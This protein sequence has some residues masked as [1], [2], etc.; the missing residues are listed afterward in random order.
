MVTGERGQRR[1]ALG[2]EG[3][4]EARRGRE[5]ASVTGELERGG[6]GGFREW[7]VSKC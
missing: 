2:G 7:P 4:S 5:R 1:G 3:G 6:G